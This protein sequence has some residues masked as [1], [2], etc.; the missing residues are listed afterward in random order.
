MKAPRLGI[1]SPQR[2]DIWRQRNGWERH[3]LTSCE[4]NVR[5]IQVALG[6]RKNITRDCL[7]VVWRR[8]IKQSGA[9]HVGYSDAIWNR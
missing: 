5:Y 2:G 6:D 9:E 8:W 3:V 7:P 4:S 1:I